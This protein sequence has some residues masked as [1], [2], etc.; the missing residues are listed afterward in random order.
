ML[1]KICRYY[2]YPDIKRQTPNQSFKWNNIT[3]T[4][5]DVD[6][7]DFLVILDYPKSDVTVKVNPN[8]I[9]HICLEPANEISKYRQFANKQSS[10]VYNQIQEGGKY[11]KSQPALPWHLDK[12]YNYFKKLKP[13]SL[14]KEDKIVWVTSNQRASIQHNKRMDFLDSISDLSFIEL[15]GRGIKEV[16]S[17][18]DVMRNAKYAIAYENF[19][20]P[21]N[22]TE[23]ISDCFL[24]YTVPLYFGC[25]RIEDYFPKEAI[26]QIDPKDKHI[27]QF[28]KEIV[29]SN[30]Y[31]QKIEALKAAR[32]LVL[33]KYQIFPF[34]SN[35]INAIVSREGIKSNE[36]KKIIS[37]KGGNDYFDNYPKSIEVTRIIRKIK[38]KIKL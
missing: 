7:C 19:K 38:N 6:E 30:N 37:I 11:I 24:S 21:F 10:V 32:T 36:K 31:N 22:W 17:K 3:F 5:E 27:K 16:D 8:H 1:V 15:Y 4:E 25:D 12:D 13:E 26:I 35:Q 23:K 34:I 14:K 18:W 20:N 29:H 9:L 33:D 28:L 2:P